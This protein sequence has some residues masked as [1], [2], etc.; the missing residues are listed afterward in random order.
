MDLLK[1]LHRTL[2]SARLAIALLLSLAATALVATLVPQGLDA[3]EYYV[4]YPR[5]WAW[6]I[7]ATGFDAF[8]K[9]ALFL[10]LAALFFVNTAV[11]TV[12]RFSRRLCTRAPKRF[13]PDLIHVG[14]LVLVA[15]G[16]V[17]A[18]TRRDGF[19]YMAEGDRVLLTEEY[20]MALRSFRFDKYADGRP[21]DWVSTVD[22][23]RNG[24][25]LVSRFAIEV[26]RPLRL[27]R[28]RVFQSGYGRQ[29]R[30]TLVDGAGREQI[31]RSGQA[32]RQG[33]VSLI[34]SA[35]EG[36]AGRTAVFERWEGH[37]ATG[38]LR[39]SVSE[40]VGGYTLAAVEERDVT[41]L[42]VVDDPGV[43]P[44]VVSLI[45]ITVGL[46]LTYAQK[47]GDRQL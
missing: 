13:G 37:T 17:T 21:R 35:I 34:L 6:L 5:F 27:G 4:R 40:T 44:V 45:L 33:Q 8:S 24:A 18:A 41:G 42:T 9:S 43:I 10:A 14:I 26:N 7:T 22:V 25:P 32:L 47:I 15:G 39:A 38:V 12:D 16:I 20:E 11:C 19:V 31:I 28:L 1:T 46:A 29:G 3:S 30:A 2:T 23:T 36:P